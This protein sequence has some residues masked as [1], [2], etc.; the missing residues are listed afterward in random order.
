M[1]HRKRLI[2]DIICHKLMST[3]VG[4]VG[5]IGELWSYY[6]T[7]LNFWWKL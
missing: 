4:D 5:F 7:V 6:W 3:H 1:G 2:I